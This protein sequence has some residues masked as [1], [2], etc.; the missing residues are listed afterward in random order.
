MSKIEKILERWRRR[1]RTVPKDEVINILKRF[2]FAIENKP[3]SHIVARHPLLIKRSQFGL[4]GELSF[5]TVNGREVK[6]Y[7]LKDILE[8]IDIIK[9]SSIIIDEEE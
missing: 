2:G 1:Q 3:G 9:K 5:A 4:D 8:A 6:Y 7:Y